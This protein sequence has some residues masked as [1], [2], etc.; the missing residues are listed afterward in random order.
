M[1]MVECVKHGNNPQSGCLPCYTSGRINAETEVERLR[2]R[3][4]CL[5]N[6]LAIALRCGSQLKDRY[7]HPAAA[8]RGTW[9]G[10]RFWAWNARREARLA[11]MSALRLA[12]RTSREGQR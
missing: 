11:R 6:R 5:E 4:A 3:V 9:S 10:R 1:S 8:V 2:E 7:Q 12:S